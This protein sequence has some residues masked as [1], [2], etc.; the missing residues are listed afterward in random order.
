MDKGSKVIEEQVGLLPFSKKF[1]KDKSNDVLYQNFV[2]ILR[3]DENLTVNKDKL[4]YTQAPTDEAIQI[5][6]FDCC[7][8]PP[9]YHEHCLKAAGNSGTKTMNE[10][11]RRTYF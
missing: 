1:L 4:L 11:L 5:I 7:R 9:I 8:R 2:Q 3:K 6:V 10:I